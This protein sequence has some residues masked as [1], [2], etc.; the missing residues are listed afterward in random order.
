MTFG[1][2]TVALKS[3]KLSIDSNIEDQEV[4][5]SVCPADYLNKELKVEGSFECIWQ[6]ESDAKSVA[7]ATP[8]VAQALSIALANTDVSIGVVPSHPTVS[9]LLDKV[10]FKEI[11][12]PFKV[13]DL[14]YQTVKFKCVYNTTNSEMIAVTTTNAVASY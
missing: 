3:L 4:L 1:G 13:K 2:N 9:I 12:R 5:S 8:N 7:L 10:Y 14:T 11:S 6:N